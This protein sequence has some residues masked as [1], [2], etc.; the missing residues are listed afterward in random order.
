MLLADMGPEFG[1]TCW[2]QQGQDTKPI[3]GGLLLAALWG[4]LIRARGEYSASPHIFLSL[5][6][7]GLPGFSRAHC[8]DHIPFPSHPPFHSL[9]EAL[10]C[11]DPCFLGIPQVAIGLK[12]SLDTFSHIGP[13]C[14]TGVCS[15]SNFLTI[16]GRQDMS[17]SLIMVMVS[18][19]YTHVETNQCI[20]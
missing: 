12:G 20:L 5:G 7:P 3:Q 15:Q 10:S 8:P 11:P 16:F 2:D 17:T 14:H 1:V 13:L 4:L 18:R 6:M 9:L 19:V